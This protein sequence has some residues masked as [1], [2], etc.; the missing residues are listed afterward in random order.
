M[1]TPVL[2]NE[3]IDVGHR[4]LQQL[5]AGGL[6]VV[7]AFW[8]R[9]ADAELWRFAVATPRLEQDSTFAAY[10]EV[11]AAVTH[12]PRPP[13]LRTIDVQVMGARDQLVTDLRAFHGTD[14]AP[15]IGGSWTSGTLGGHYLDEVYLYRAERLFPR[16]GAADV[17]FAV[18]D[19]QTKKWSVH[20][21]SWTFSSGLLTG[22]AS[23]GNVVHYRQHRTGLTTTFAVVEQAVMKG[24]RYLV[25]LRWWKFSN[26]TLIRVKD[27]VRLVPMADAQ[28]PSSA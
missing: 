18:R 5:D 20:P 6:P 1:D 11:N 4:I 12:V 14:P 28:S 22:I 13:S 15:F 8:Y 2:V 27:E 26:G 17:Q 16:N 9:P 10:H 23:A 24:R 21:G 25:S 19:R 3:H 7:A